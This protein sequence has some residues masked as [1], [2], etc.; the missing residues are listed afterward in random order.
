MNKKQKNNYYLVVHGRKPGLYR[1]WFGEEGA[2]DQV[3]GIPEALFKGFATLQEA[4]AWLNEMDEVD[5]LLAEID[6]LLG[7]TANHFTDPQT[8]ALQ[9]ID[10][11]TALNTSKVVIFTDGGCDPNPGPG[12]YG[13]VLLFKDTQGIIHRRELSGGFRLTTNNRMELQACIEGLRALK[14]ASPVTLYSDSKYVVDAMT[15]GWAQRW[16]ING[17][18]RQ[19]DNKTENIDLWAQLLELCKTH[20]VEFCWVKGH[21]GIPENERCDQLSTQSI[22]QPNLPPDTAYEEGKTQ[23]PT[24]QL[25]F[26]PK[27]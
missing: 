5:D 9:P 4:R 19:K 11:Q 24:L 3:Q 15:L 16:Q 23:I 1:Q 17:W 10:Y 2:A 27:E 26:M 25:E 7:P 22:K 12:G 18:Y 21:A 13:A 6:M 20:T 14:R 8:E